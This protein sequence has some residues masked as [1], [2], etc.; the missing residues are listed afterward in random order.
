MGHEHVITSLLENAVFLERG[1][2]HRRPTVLGLFDARAPATASLSGRPETRKVAR[3]VRGSPPDTTPQEMVAHIQR[4]GCNLQK[5][6][7]IGAHN[8]C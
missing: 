1:E 4:A 2:P 3:R 8:H 5:K 7:V 6:S